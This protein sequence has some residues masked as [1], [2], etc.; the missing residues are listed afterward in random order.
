M[1]TL[2]SETLRLSMRSWIS[3]DL[4]RVGPYWLLFVWT[5]LFSV[6]LAAVF[7][8]LGF[9]VFNPGK[10]GL[11]TP[12]GWLYWFGKNLVIS[13]TVSVLIQLLFDGVGWL[14]GG[15]A[16][17]R[18]WSDVQRSLFFAGI[19]ILGV[20]I[21]WPLGIAL[22]G[23]GDIVF[24]VLKDPRSLLATVTLGLGISV[25]LH[26]YFAAK[27]KQIAAEARAT[28][29]QLRLLQGQIEPH[30]LF[31][32]MAGVISLID[33]DAERAKHMLQAFT[34]YLRSS[35]TT[36]RRDEGPLSQELELAQNYLLLMQ[37]R[38][39]DRLQFRIEADDAARRATLPPLLLQPLVENAVQHGL[40]PSVDGGEV[41]IRAHV[42]GGQL[43]L[44]VCDNGLGLDAP[45]RRARGPGSA[46]N[47]V[48]LDNVRSRLRSRWG[49][50]ARLDLHAAQ[51]GTRAVITLPLEVK[52]AGPRP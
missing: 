43:V 2:S 37:A 8:L 35:L 25:V 21:G 42:Q 33:H 38:M 47:G 39:E 13:A 6:V 26:F 16:A 34:E 32:T 12:A 30:F 1:S 48:A 5:G 14:L 50:A 45:P 11:G 22:S 27:G 51:P 9:F 17:I 24:P 28:E 46:S 44:E 49:D 3:S 19:P 15:P 31:N 18:R 4:T 7:T 29:A 52:A 41:V 23:S 10:T 40:E 20:L 36:L